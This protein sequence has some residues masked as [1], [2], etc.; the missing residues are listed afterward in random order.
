MSDMGKPIPRSNKSLIDA[1]SSQN[2]CL[3]S[4]ILRGLASVKA[5]LYLLLYDIYLL[6]DQIKKVAPNLTKNSPLMEIVFAGT[7]FTKNFGCFRG[8]QLLRKEEPWCFR[9]N[10][11]ASYI[12]ILFYSTNKHFTE[13][14]TDTNIINYLVFLGAGSCNS[15]STSNVLL[16]FFA[17]ALIR[18]RVLCLVYPL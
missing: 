15:V 11:F 5:L 18:S 14:I 4:E 2:N 9:W 1:N 10:A 17:F 3:L 7:S 8:N 6:I 12:N 13:S 16:R